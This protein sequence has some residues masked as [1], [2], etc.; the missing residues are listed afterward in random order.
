MDKAP[1][2][3]HLGELR[4]RIVIVLIAVVITFSASF[5]FSEDIFRLLTSPIHFIL[6]FSLESPYITRIPTKNPNL[7]L[8]F[9]APAEA[10][11]MHFKISFISAIIISSPIIFFEIWRF[12]AP[13]LLKKERK[14]AI[15]FVFTTT[16]LFLI[17]ALFC[18]VIVL[19]F[20]MNFLLTYKTAN[21]QPMISVGKYTDFCLK[22]ILAFGAIFELPVIVVFLTKMGIVTTDYLAKNRKYAVL[23][24]FVLAAFLTPTPD[25]FNQTLMAVP[26]LLLYEAGILASRILDKKK[27]KAEKAEKA[28]KETE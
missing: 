13:G 23:I 16:F 12:I 14:Y 20:A 26:I 9:L 19:P 5:Y 3:E 4:N 25:A 17:G 21:L 1:L 10:L 28:D 2:T 24:A 8:V 11:W 22:F 7:N 27:K 18:F 6:N 15:P